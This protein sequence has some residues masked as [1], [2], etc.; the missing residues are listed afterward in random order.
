[1][2][3]H[4]IVQGVL[5]DTR[6]GGVLTMATIVDVLAFLSLADEVEAAFFARYETPENEIMLYAAK[7]GFPRQNG[8]HTIERGLCHERRV[9]SLKRLAR[10][11]DVDKT[12]VKRVVQHP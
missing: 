8:L 12:N 9:L 11:L 6:G 1:M 2:L 3:V 4:E 7:Y 5:P 10:A